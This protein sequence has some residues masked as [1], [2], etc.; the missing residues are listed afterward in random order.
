MNIVAKTKYFLQVYFVLTLLVAG[1]LLCFI[2]VLKVS[3]KLKLLMRLR[4]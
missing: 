4:I 3:Y 1:K 2:L